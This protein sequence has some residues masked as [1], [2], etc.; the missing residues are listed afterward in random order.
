MPK[1]PEHAE[2]LAAD[3]SVRRVRSRFRELVGGEGLVR[4]DGA[5]KSDPQFILRR[6][7]PVC[8]VDLFGATYFL[9]GYLYDDG[10]GFFVGFFAPQNSKRARARLYARIFYKD[11]SLMWRVASHFVHDTEEFWIGK[12]D[13]RTVSRNGSEWSSTLEESTNLPLEIQAAFDVA[14]GCRAAK[15]DDHAIERILRRGPSGRIRPYADFTAPRRR[16]R[17]RINGGRPVARFGRPGDPSSLTFVD[18]YEPDLTSGV[19]ERSLTKSEFFGGDLHKVRVLSTN[20]K[21]QYMFFASPTH[22]WL[23]PPQA[24]TEELS[25]YGVRLVDVEAPDDLFVPGYEY[26]EEEDGMVTHSQIPYG[27]A[28][29]P[30]PDD[31]HRADASRWL[32][33]L[34]VIQQFRRHVL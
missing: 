21:I 32:E 15:R 23:N 6:Y 16:N 27:Y 20:R 33:A 4:I 28:G 8:A 1:G 24:L 19:V 30:H 10:L 11:S 34:P 14:R 18:G 17:I 22:A 31:P 2:P 5:G 25:T 3:C 12:G 7:A 13:V 9:S 29:A 26:H